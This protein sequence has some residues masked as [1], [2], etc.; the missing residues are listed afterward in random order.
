MR[1]GKFAGVPVTDLP[2]H[3]LN[4]LQALPNLREPLRSCV[5]FEWQRRLYQEPQEPVRVDR[6]AIRVAPEHR[7]LFGELVTAGYRATAQRL[8]P[9][10]GGSTEGMRELNELM[11]AL[12]EQLN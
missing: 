4:W 10:H 3:Y 2:T 12:R 8:H 6:D 1:F 7:E 9:D 11:A 5:R